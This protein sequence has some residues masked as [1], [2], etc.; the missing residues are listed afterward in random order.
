MLKKTKLA[1][2]LL[3]LVDM[4]EDAEVSS[5]VIGSIIKQSK[6]CLFQNVKRTY[7]VFYFLLV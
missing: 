6:D 7:E 2:T 1:K 5:G 4:A 3:V